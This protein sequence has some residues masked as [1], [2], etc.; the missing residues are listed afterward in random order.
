MSVFNR[1]SYSSSHEAVS[2]NM[3]TIDD[4][5][6]EEENDAE[7]NGREGVFEQAEPVPTVSTL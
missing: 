4:D 3:L 6:S 2:T 7:D 5:A 1:A